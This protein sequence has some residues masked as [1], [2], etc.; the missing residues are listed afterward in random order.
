MKIHPKNHLFAINCTILYNHLKLKM[1][2]LY[3]LVFLKSSS[4]N[5]KYSCLE[6][7]LNNYE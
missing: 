2:S 1:L 4:I 3:K 7:G 6:K 5:I